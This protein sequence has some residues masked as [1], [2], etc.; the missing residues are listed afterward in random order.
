MQMFIPAGHGIL[1][2]CGFHLTPLHAAA[3]DAQ[4]H[5]HHLAPLTRFAHNDSLVVAG[6]LR[7]GGRQCLAL[8]RHQESTETEDSRQDG[9]SLRR[10]LTS[11]QGRSHSRHTQGSQPHPGRHVPTPLK[12]RHHAGNECHCHPHERKELGYVL[13]IHSGKIEVIGGCK[14]NNFD[15]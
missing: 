5:L 14:D 1:Q 12:G 13:T 11:R 10:R 3:H 15:E 4:V 7:Q 8:P 9:G 2:Q 6:A